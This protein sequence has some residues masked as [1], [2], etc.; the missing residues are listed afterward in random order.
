LLSRGSGCPILTSLWDQ[1]KKA[2]AAKSDRAKTG[3]TPL[4][5]RVFFVKTA[6]STE[7][8]RGPTR[9]RSRSKR[10]KHKSRRDIR[11]ERKRLFLEAFHDNIDSIGEVDA[12]TESQTLNVDRADVSEIQN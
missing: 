5:A 8:R 2:L 10:E 12:L 3:K 11:E 6:G 9:Q 4:L 7:T 1:R